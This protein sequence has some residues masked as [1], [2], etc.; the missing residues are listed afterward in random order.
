MQEAVPLPDQIDEAVNYIKSL[1]TKVKMA[2]EKKERLLMGR[3]R[4]RGCNC[5][6]AFETKESLK[7]TKI[8]I[9]ELG[10]TLEVVLKCGFENQ[11]IFNEM[12]RI[13]HEENIEVMSA[14]SS[15]AGDSMIHV[16]HA[17]VRVLWVIHSPWCDP[18]NKVLQRN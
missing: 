16:V 15:L 2:K 18:L 5:S 13:L 11:F 12:I 1:E 14:N 3:K 6:S 8:E 17:E 7:S 10:S 4:S 9:H